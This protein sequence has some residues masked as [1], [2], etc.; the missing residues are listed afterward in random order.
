MR[1]FYLRLPFTRT[2]AWVEYPSATRGRTFVDSLRDPDAFHLWIG[3]AYCVVG[4][5]HK[6]AAEETVKAV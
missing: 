6:R 4:W 5:R 3:R 2:D 1:S